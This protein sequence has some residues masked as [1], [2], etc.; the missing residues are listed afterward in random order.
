MEPDVCG[1]AVFV[2]RSYFSVGRIQSTHSS[3]GGA[4]SFARKRVMGR[5]SIRRFLKIWTRRGSDQV[6]SRCEGHVGMP[7]V[8]A[9]GQNNAVAK[10][11]KHTESGSRCNSVGCRGGG[12]RCRGRGGDNCSNGKAIVVI[13]LLEKFGGNANFLCF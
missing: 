9:V 4:G 6:E 13:C 11:E 10:P 12:C 5:V 2:R 3:G 1:F 7:T 8:T